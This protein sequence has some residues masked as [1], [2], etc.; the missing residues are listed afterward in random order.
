M[1]TTKRCAACAMELRDEA[2]RCP[3]CRAVQPGAV[4]HR[5]GEGRALL[6]VCLALSRQFGMDVA[7]LRVAFVIA[8]AVSGG[9]ALG[10]YLLLWAFTPPSA[11][12]KAPVQRFV[13]WLTGPAE[14]T[15]EPKVERR[16]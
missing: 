5:G 3:Q 9:S 11:I 7:L 4:M 1:D 15:A 6:G 12:G 8:L 16:V 2:T 10:V 13:A 14:G